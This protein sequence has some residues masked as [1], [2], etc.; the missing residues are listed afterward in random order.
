MLNLR[1]KTIIIN[2]R[3]ISSPTV[4][5]M[6]VINLKSFHKLVESEEEPSLVWTEGYPLPPYSVS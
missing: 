1:W 3:L 5:K 2:V 6:I 4:L